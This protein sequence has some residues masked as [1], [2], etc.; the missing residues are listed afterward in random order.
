MSVKAKRLIG[1]Y[2]A[3][4]LVTLS[5]LSAVLYEKLTD[6]ARAAGY[7]SGETFETAVKAADDMSEAL[8]KSV[9]ATDGGMCGKICAEVYADALAAESAIAALPF[10]T[11]ELEQTAG[12]I[13]TAGDYAYSLCAEAAEQGFSDGQRQELKELSAAAADYAEK[14]RQLQGDINNGLTAI[15]ETQE[16]LYNVSDGELTTLSSVMLGYEDGFA[17]LD[18]LS[19]D[20]AYGAEK[21]REEG[22]LSEEEMEALAAKAAGVEA[23]ELKLEY[24]YEGDG[25][26]RCYSAGD[27]SIC[28]SSRGVESIA[29]SRLLGGG[30]PDAKEAEKTALKF[31]KELGY[32]GLELCA[33]KKGSGTLIMSFAPAQDGAV[34]IDNTLTVSVAAEDGSVYAF[35]AENYSAE[36]V[37]CDWSVN[38]DEAAEKLPEGVDAQEAR[39]VIIKSAGGRNVPC[40]EF[41]CAGE[42]GETVKIYV[43]AE[44]GTQCRIEV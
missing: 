33:S 4:A 35:S 20:G 38:E 40:Y 43:D 22:N 11:Y 25:L 21:E 26:R 34:C 10:D 7:V 2:T 24:E 5:V 6:Y 39:K 23:R 30:E 17:E 18:K 36:T 8:K 15:D 44:K 41:S 27:T 16:R 1:I 29:R 19:Y 42:D 28:V 31:L 14:L 13:N 12:F 9:Y 37:Q 3:A 32:E